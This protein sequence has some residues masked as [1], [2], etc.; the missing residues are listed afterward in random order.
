MPAINFQARRRIESVIAGLIEA[1]DDLDG[2]CDL[3]AVSQYEGG[4]CDDEGQA[5][6]DGLAEQWK[7][8]KPQGEWVVA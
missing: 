1:L 2:D 7:H 6:F 3:E 8:Q 5:D 4:Q